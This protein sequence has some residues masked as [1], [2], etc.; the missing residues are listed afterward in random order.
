M[1]L[2]NPKA[3]RSIFEW[4][5]K[6]TVQPSQSTGQKEPENLCDDCSDKQIHLHKAEDTSDLPDDKCHK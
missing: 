6:K 1:N 4:I 3:N 2:N 5:L